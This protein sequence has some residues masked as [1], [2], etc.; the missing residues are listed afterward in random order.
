M[1]TAIKEQ[2]VDV[3]RQSI[4]VW[5]GNDVPD[6]FCNIVAKLHPAGLYVNVNLFFLDYGDENGAHL[7]CITSLFNL[8]PIF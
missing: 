2:Q 3:D 6:V 5:F 7:R 4:R 1:V 8:L